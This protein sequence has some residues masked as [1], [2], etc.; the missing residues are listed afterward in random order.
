MV[1]S[2][3]QFFAAECNIVTKEVGRRRSFLPWN[4]T[5]CWFMFCSWAECGQGSRVQIPPSRWRQMKARQ[6]I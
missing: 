3:V 6:P 2:Q 1:Q 5:A 4:T